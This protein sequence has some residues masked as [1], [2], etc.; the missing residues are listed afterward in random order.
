MSDCDTS[1]QRNLP[2]RKRIRLDQANYQAPS[3]RA[4]VTITAADRHPVFVNAAFTEACVVMLCEQAERDEIGIL[5]Y[6]FMPDH[7]HLLVQVAGPTNLID[8]VGAFKGRT[9][10]LAWK[11]ELSGRLWQR[12]FY[13]HVLRENEDPKV[14][15][16]Y[17]LDNP[18]RR[19]LIAAWHEYPFSGSFV[20]D[21][22]DERF[23]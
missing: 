15:L 8:F 13:D 1:R 18:V 22:R 14:R 19:G 16:R 4:A 7:L 12:S 20:Y 23:W 10:R 9:T 17:I 2:K 6:C 3:T 11:H 5:G 21:L